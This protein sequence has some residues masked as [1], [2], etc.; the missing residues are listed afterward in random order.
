MD[1]SN[2]TP[3]AEDAVVTV[4]SLDEG[5]DVDVDVIDVVEDADTDGDDSC[6]S[7]RLVKEPDDVVPVGWVFVGIGDVDICC[8]VSVFVSSDAVV[9]VGV[10]DDA[11]GCG[12]GWRVGCG[13]GLDVGCGIG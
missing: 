5:D 10:A 9:N 12:V 4:A 3:V 7:S 8:T 2:E 11:V 13:V 1:G 6:V